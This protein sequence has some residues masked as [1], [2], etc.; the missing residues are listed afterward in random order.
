[1]AFERQPNVSAVR[2]ADIRVSLFDPD[3][4]DS[5]N[6]VRD[7]RTQEATAMIEVI[8]SDGSARQVRADIADHFSAQVLNQLRTF[9]ASVRTKANAEILP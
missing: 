7:N 8:M 6:T 2:I 1:M 4:Q 3:P 5:G 9:V